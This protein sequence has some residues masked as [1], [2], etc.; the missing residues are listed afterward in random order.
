MGCGGCATLTKS[1]VKAVNHFARVNGNFS[2]YPSKI[3]SGLAFIRLQRG[4]FYANSLDDPQLHLT[5]LDDVYAFRKEDYAVS[6]KIDV[7][8]RIIDK[9]T[10][11]LLLLSSDK[12]SA[13]LVLQSS[14]FG[15]NLDS[16]CTMYNSIDKVRKLPT[17]I[18]AAIG[19]LVASGGRQ[20]IRTRQARE[21]RKF[22]PQADTLIAVMTANLLEFLQSTNIQEL[23]A[24]EEKGL[25]SNYLS[26]LRQ[27]KTV[28]TMNSARDTALIVSNTR[29]TIAL[30]REYLA[31]KSALDAVKTLQEQTIRATRRLRKAH[32]LLAQSV[33]K[34]HDLK[35]VVWEF[36]EAFEGIKDIKST[37]QQI[38]KPAN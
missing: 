24:N 3:M 37:V 25:S 10:Q 6:R 5:E 19:Q 38:D 11:S 4:V 29:S 23:I 9:Y 7:T 36:Q 16:L 14:G 15:T 28:T 13:D 27:A 21:I 17:G 20:F 26:Y 8:F 12:Y 33:Q 35:E 22:V 32:L 30:D 2:A 18:G 34:K 1:Q 31:L